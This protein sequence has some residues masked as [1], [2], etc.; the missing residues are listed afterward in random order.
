MRDGRRTQLGELERAVM[1]Q[2]WALARPATVRDVHQALSQTREIAYTTVMTVLDRLAKKGSVEQSR[3]GRAYLYR[4]AVDR[5]ELTAELM[6]EALGT[7]DGDDRT[8]ALVRFVDTASA[9]DTAALRAAL[10]EL[11]RREQAQ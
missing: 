7:V 10:A 2:L 3:D 6:H 8:S 9:D 11:E 1:E 4:P 5:D